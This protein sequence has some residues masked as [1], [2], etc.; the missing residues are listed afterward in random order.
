MEGI[1]FA[2]KMLG[3]WGFVML[4]LLLFAP[5]GDTLIFGKKLKRQTVIK[6]MIIFFWLLSSLLILWGVI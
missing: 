1:F 2:L 5:K 3:F 4:F 6:I